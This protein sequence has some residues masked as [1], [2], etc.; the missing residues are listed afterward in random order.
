L[1]VPVPQQNSA[2]QK[3]E[4]HDVARLGEFDGLADQGFDITFEQA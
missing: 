1:R 3:L 4:H 2:E